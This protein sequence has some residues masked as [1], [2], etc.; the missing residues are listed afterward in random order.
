MRPSSVHNTLIDNPL[1]NRP[2]RGKKT[3][4]GKLD[5][6]DSETC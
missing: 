1:R 3:I 5:F 6:L 4:L 2:P